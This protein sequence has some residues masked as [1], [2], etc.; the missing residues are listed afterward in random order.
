MIATSLRGRVG[1]MRAGWRLT[2]CGV[3][4]PIPYEK[5]GQRAGEIPARRKI[6]QD[7]SDRVD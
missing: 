2:V 4:V 3:F 7:L 1:E 6:S 5:G